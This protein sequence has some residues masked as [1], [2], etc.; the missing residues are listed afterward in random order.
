[1]GSGRRGQWDEAGSAS[2]SS[3][4]IMGS[5]CKAQSRGRNCVSLPNPVLQP[6]SEAAKSALVLFLREQT[7]SQKHSTKY[8]I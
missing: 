5:G 7:G 6:E 1:M 8:Q 4:P 3:C 2:D